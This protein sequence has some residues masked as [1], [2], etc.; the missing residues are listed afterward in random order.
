M[1]NTHKRGVLFREEMMEG[2][3]PSSCRA[4]NF[5]YDGSTNPWDHVCRFVALF[6]SSRRQSRSNLTLYGMRQKDNEPLRAYLKRFTIA[7]LEVPEASQDVLITSFS[8]GL[9]EGDFYTSL[10]KK[11]PQSWDELLQ[12]A[13]KYVNLEDA[14]RLKNV[15]TPA[16]EHA[17][18]DRT[19]AIVKD[20]RAE[21]KEMPREVK[22][23]WL[24]GEKR[25]GPRYN[26]YT[27]LVS[28][29]SQVLMAIKSSP[30]LKWPGTWSERPKNHPNAGNGQ[31][32]KFHNEYGHIT[33]DCHHLRHG[34]SDWYSRNAY[35]STRLTFE[36]KKGGIGMIGALRI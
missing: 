26:S 33:D 7:T 25:G 17:Q 11:G 6:A 20:N 18:M 29:P 24:G 10:A 34:W 35:P 28:P 15:E 4:I 13:A 3:L 31:L 22:G 27:P 36:A 30:L 12:R 16:R 2:D 21:R 1:T 8:Q 14:L 9:H 5:E 19:S 23:L 32:C